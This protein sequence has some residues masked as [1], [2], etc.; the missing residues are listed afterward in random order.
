VFV[1]GS[2]L[3]STVRACSVPSRFSSPPKDTIDTNP[4]GLLAIRTVSPPGL[5]SV[6]FAPRVR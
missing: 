4:V 2:Q 1:R 6:S 3:V 5:D